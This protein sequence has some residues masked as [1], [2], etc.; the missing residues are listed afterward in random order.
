MATL[1]GAKGLTPATCAAPQ[2]T[3]GSSA[4]EKRQVEDAQCVVR[5]HIEQISARKDIIRKHR[6][7]G[8]PLL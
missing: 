1:D 5:W 6:P 3:P 8:I 7:D 4:L 2:I